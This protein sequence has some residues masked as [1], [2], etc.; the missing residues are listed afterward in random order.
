MKKI[1]SIDGGGIRGIIP[2]QILVALEKKLQIKT[3]N[4]DAR[5]A[6][7]FDFFAGSS[8]GGILTCLLLCPKDKNPSMPKF[9]AKQA[10]DLYIDNGTKIFDTSFWQNITNGL[11][12]EK[13]PSKPIEKILLKY[14]GNAKLSNLLK[15]CIITAY[16]IMERKTHFF[17]QHDYNRKGDGGDF[18][19]RDVCR[20]TS[21]A[22][23]YFEAALIKSISGVSYPLIDGGIF[24]NDPAL[25][26]YS[27]VRN[28]K[29]LPT[30]KDMF[31]LSLGTGGENKSY[32]YAE[33]KDWGA[34]GWIKPVL[35]I[36]MSASAETTHYHLLKMFAAQGN[37]RNYMRIQPNSL[38]NAKP[39]MDN[40][41]PKNLMALKEVGIKT[42]ENCNNDLDIIVDILMEGE[43]KVEY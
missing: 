8:T 25:C 9:T 36:M 34:L 30:A 11:L 1:L 3:K 14:F 40:A 16:D 23:T 37:Q 13:Y 7:F 38:G 39:D 20:A 26:A 2:G 43:D 5:I 28:A 32:N 27:E 17:A 42:A 21:A 35:D 22:P 18:Y 29:G 12:D 10:V 19:I 24:A 41:S 33:A 15:P 4:P 6:H 31:I